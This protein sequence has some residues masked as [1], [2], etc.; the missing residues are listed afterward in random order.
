MPALRQPVIEPLGR[1][2]RRIPGPFHLGVG[3]ADIRRLCRRRPSSTA[4]NGSFS[5]D[6]EGQG[7]SCC[8]VRHSPPSAAGYGQTA[9][10]VQHKEQRL[11]FVLYNGFPPGSSYK[12]CADRSVPAGYSLVPLHGQEAALIL[13]GQVKGL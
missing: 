11:E 13:Q 6:T 7:K 1:R 12:S 3:K 4:Y 9:A 2:T 8:S 10:P 5:A